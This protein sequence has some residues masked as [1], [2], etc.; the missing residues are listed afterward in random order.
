MPEIKQITKTDLVNII[1]VLHAT[2]NEQKDYLSKLDTE[3]GDG[4]HGFSMMT[5]FTRFHD[6]LDSYV[7]L[8]IGQM[9]K[10]G[11]FDL[12]SAIGGAAGAVFGTFFKGQGAYYQEY[13]DGK[14]SLSLEDLANMMVEA[15]KQIKT[16]GKAEI[17]D[18]TMIDALEPAVNELVR[19]AENNLSLN[20]AFKKAAAE[21]MQGAENTKNMVGKRGRSKNL[22]ERSLGFMDAGAMS[23]Y[24]IFK[25]YADYLDPQA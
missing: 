21:A 6:N 13:L 7:D 17:G 10:K 8:S 18:K 2:F 11:G 23:M 4:D 25:T 15:L 3:I 16:I 24:F 14:E 22:G 20:E 5:G 9:L 19:S 12:I 1:K